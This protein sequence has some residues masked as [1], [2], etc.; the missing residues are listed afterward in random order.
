MRLNPNASP[1]RVLRLAGRL[2]ALPVI[3]SFALA[4]CAP[5]PRRTPEDFAAATP[6]ET[7][8][9]DPV[10]ARVNNTVIRLSDLRQELASQGLVAPSEDVDLSAADH[11]RVLD[12][13]IDQRLLA[14]EARRRGLQDSDEARRRL[15]IAE[16]RI[17][18]NVLVETVVDE[19]VTDE[20]IR[21]I[22]DAQIRLIPLGEEVRARHIL[23]DTQEEAAEV[24]R[25]IDE[26]ADF[27]DLAVAVSLDPA[28][29]L[30]G[31]D[32][33]YFPRDGILPEF[34]EVAFNT[35]VGDV[36]DPFRSEFGW[37]VMEVVHRRRQAPPSIEQL[38]PNIVSYL[39]F[40][41][42]ESLVEGLRDSAEVERYD[43]PDPPAAEDGEAGEPGEA[44]P[45]AGGAPED[46]EPG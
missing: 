25:L 15:A 22:Y 21:R 17:L 45:D 32:L 11:A 37:H 26:G 34:G 30:E 4:A 13:L 24:K 43:L 31:G 2:A 40:D 42:M 28:T 36:S 3:L 39:T 18:G 10:V 16:E 35:P 20:A 19:A 5:E 6:A 23:V 7:N 9:A 46:G 44:G 27:S 8:A 12:E 38:R 1:G 33:G 14:L 29:R 41:Q